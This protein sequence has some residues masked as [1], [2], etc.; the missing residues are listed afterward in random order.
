METKS[1]W[2]SVDPA[3]KVKQI[4]VSGF[5]L[6]CFCIRL[7]CLSFDCCESEWELKGIVSVCI[8]ISQPFQLSL[9]L[10][11]RRT[12]VA[13][14]QICFR[15]GKEECSVGFRRA[16]SVFDEE[17]LLHFECNDLKHHQRRAERSVAHRSPD[18]CWPSITFSHPIDSSHNEECMGACVLQ[19]PISL[20]NR[21]LLFV[22]LV[23][24]LSGGDV[25]MS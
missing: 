19:L 21:C 17:A 5:E 20:Q 23:K 25:E 11:I 13:N 9:A 14:M 18:T 4:S 7:F 3:P 22:L 2:T 24:N 16:L 1:L 8:T 6:N 10:E 15:E 12:R